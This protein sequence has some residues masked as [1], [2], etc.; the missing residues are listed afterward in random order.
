MALQSTDN[1]ISDGELTRVDLLESYS[2]MVRFD[3]GLEAPSELTRISGVDACNTV[4]EVL[5]FAAAVNLGQS[6]STI[7]T[8]FGCKYWARKFDP[9]SCLNVLSDPHVLYTNVG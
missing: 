6:W 4:L 7:L 2:I 1:M 9:R 8:L 3:R 5:L